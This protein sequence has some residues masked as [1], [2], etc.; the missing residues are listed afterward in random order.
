[1]ASLVIM[2]NRQ[3][4]PTSIGRL[5]HGEHLCV[6]VC[7]TECVCVCMGLLNIHVHTLLHG[8]LCD[9]GLVRWLCGM[10]PRP[11]SS[12]RGVVDYCVIYS[13][14]VEVTMGNTSTSHTVLEHCSHH[15]RNA[16]ITVC[17]SRN[18]N[19]L[20]LVNIVC[21][22]VWNITMWYVCGFCY[23]YQSFSLPLPVLPVY[24]YL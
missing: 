17:C 18:G 5:V 3:F 14:H 23:C 1:M 11:T 13:G 21:T 9:V 15:W 19:R 12:S 16:Y 8:L 20:S 2:A 7:V 24:L 4:S 10:V 6:C 22:V